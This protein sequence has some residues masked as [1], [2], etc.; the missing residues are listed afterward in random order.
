MDGAE[1]AENAD[2]SIGDL[3][4]AQVALVSAVAHLQ[5]REDAVDPTAQLDVAEKK[6]VLAEDGDRRIAEIELCAGDLGHFFGEHRRYSSASQAHAE[7]GEENLAPV[8]VRNRQ[9]QN[10]DSVDHQAPGPHP[11]NL[12]EDPVDE[13]VRLYVGGGQVE[14]PQRSARDR[15]LEV[16]T[17]S[18][19]PGDYRTEPLEEGDEKRLLPFARSLQREVRGEERLADAHAACQHG[20]ASGWQASS[21]ERVELGHAEC[22]ARVVGGRIQIIRGGERLEAGADSNSFTA[23]LERVAACQVCAAADLDDL[24][25]AQPPQTMGVER[26]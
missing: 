24:G 4:F 19:R 15:W 5:H 10:A 12:G 20:G 21:H 23:D 16:E 9:L 11:R 25:P 7:R 1:R 2:P 18:L 8:G 14:E 17:D 3:E 6:Q 13:D 22:G 26:Q